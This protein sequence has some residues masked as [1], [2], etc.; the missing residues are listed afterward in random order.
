MRPHIFLLLFLSC[1]LELCATPQ[2]LEF[3]GI[4][5][6]HS[7]TKFSFRDPASG[8]YK[9]IVLGGTFGEYALVAYVP[10]T[11]TAELTR[12]AEHL[13]VKINAASRGALS[14]TQVS[15]IRENLLRLGPAGERY[16]LENAKSTA[17]A[18][19][20][21]G[22]GLFL[23]SLPPVADE[24][25]AGLI[26]DTNSPFLMVRTSSGEVITADLRQSGTPTEYIVKR[27][28]TVAKIAAQQGI[29]IS[30]LLALNQGVDFSRLHVG[31]K[32]RV[33]R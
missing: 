6:D 21:I 2:S 16:C 30:D 27:G 26:Y 22:P 32:L 5:T 7:A 17:V 12:S 28:D 33:R 23:A 1:A 18:T 20:L 25:Y 29:S 15:K 24:D 4:A 11:Q 9:W 14:D 31:S 3:D 8:V 10:A 19:D 13:R